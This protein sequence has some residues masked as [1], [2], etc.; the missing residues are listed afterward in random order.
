L[1]GGVTGATPRCSMMVY[2]IIYTLIEII[3]DGL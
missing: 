1:A 3:A 2:V